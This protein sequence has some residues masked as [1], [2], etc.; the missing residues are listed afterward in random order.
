MNT[1][2]TVIGI[3]AGIGVFLAA[4]YSVS[5][6]LLLRGLGQVL[7]GISFA[8]VLIVMGAL[9]EREIGFARIAA[10]PLFLAATATLW[11]EPRLYKIMPALVMVFALVLMLGYVALD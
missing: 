4:M 1:V 10:A 11:F 7:H 2:M 5:Q 3:F 9:M 6:V 8:L